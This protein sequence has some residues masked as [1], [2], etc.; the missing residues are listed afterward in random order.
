MPITT[1]PI[2]P[3]RLLLDPNN[4]RFHDL[5]SYKKV[6][7]RRYGEPSVQAKTL[8]ILHSTDKFDLQALK[9][10]IVTNGFVPLEQIVVE[11]Y[12][13]DANGK[14]YLVVEGNRRVAAIKSLLDEYVRAV[15]T[16]SEETLATLRD[17]PVSE[18]TGTVDERRVFRQTLMAIRHVAGTREWGAYQQAKL[19][20]ELYEQED[21]DFGQV[22][23]RIGIRSR[24]AARRFRAIKALHQMEQ[25]EEFGEY[26]VP[27]LYAFFNEAIAVPTVRDWI[28]WSDQTNLAENDEAR[29]AFYEL[30]V[31]RPAEN[32]EYL[33]AK[34]QDIRQVRKLKNIVNKTYARTVLLDSDRA[35]EDAEKAANESPTEDS[36]SIVENALVQAS[37]ALN[38]PGIDAWL[39]PTLRGKELLTRLVTIVDKIR[40]LMEH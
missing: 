40:T 25:D 17:L 22:A 38:Q 26:A 15:V 30:V 4:Y 10:S 5:D 31:S 18:L 3:D 1:I 2:S 9:D 7:P 34:I 11:E 36:S 24:E 14:R 28:G 13:T 29:R 32:G 37:H 35:F 33:P 19:I 16:I 8:S 6:N 21:R 20:E 39:N 23:Q 27:R 12:D